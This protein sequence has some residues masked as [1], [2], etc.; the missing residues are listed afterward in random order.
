MLN[1]EFNE[2]VNSSLHKETTG[3][4]VLLANASKELHSKGV[5]EVRELIKSTDT[6]LPCPTIFKNKGSEKHWRRSQLCPDGSSLWKCVLSSSEQRR[7][8]GSRNHH[9]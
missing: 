3:V 5:R 1:G 4:Y 2:I 7:S 8:L 6:G 9:S